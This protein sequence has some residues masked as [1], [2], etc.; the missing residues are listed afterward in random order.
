MPS[1]RVWYCLRLNVVPK[2]VRGNGEPNGPSSEEPEAWSEDQETR[3]RAGFVYGHAGQTGSKAWVQRITIDGDRT[4][5][6]LG[7]YP[8]V[9]LALARKKSGDLRSAVAEGRDPRA[10]RRQPN[11]PTFQEVAEAYIADNAGR[12]K[13]LKQAINWH[14]SLSTYAYPVFG[15]TRVDRITRADVLRVLQP[16][17][18]TKPSLAKKLRQ[19]VRSIFGAAMAFD[20]IDLNPAG[21][22]IDA[23]LPR[24]PAVKAHFRGFALPGRRRRASEGR[25]LGRVPGFEA[26]L[27]VPPADG[28][29]VRRSAGRTVG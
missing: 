25:G 10:E 27:S 2:G 15:N 14:G 8:D 7:G 16:I 22:V 19:R 9:S 11:L 21:E 13:T 28:G 23:A 26:V 17:W 5:I 24:T 29:A 1:G 20:Y 6:G 12:W 3:R 18:T 4:D